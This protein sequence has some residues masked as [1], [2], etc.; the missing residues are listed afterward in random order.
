[1]VCVV[2]TGSGMT[3][4]VRAKAFE[5]FFTTKDPGKGSG[6][7]LSQILVLQNSQAEAFVWTRGSMKEPPFPFIFPALTTKRNQRRVLRHQAHQ[8]L[9]WLKY[10]AGR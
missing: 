2:D 7:G 3:D 1:M 10:I 8:S 9:Q 4:E 5:P 6:L